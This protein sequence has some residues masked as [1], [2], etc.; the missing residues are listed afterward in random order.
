MT[1]HVNLTSELERYVNAKVGAGDYASADELFTQ[2]VQHLQSAEAHRARFLAAIA[3]G[4]DE[5]DRGEG[6][7]YSR[8]LMDQILADALAGNPDDGDYDTDV[9]GFDT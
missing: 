8:A 5:L 6:I 2:A 9:V 1:M 4:R 7:I 3:V